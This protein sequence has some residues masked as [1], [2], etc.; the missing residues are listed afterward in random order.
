M[1]DR[2]ITMGLSN[3]ST[4]LYA[5]CS[6]GGLTAY[7]HT[8]YIR[9]RLPITVRVL[10]LADA[11]FSLE[12]DGFGGKPIY[13]PRMQWVY[14]AMNAS[15]SVN[16]ACLKACGSGNGWKCMF[17]ANVAPFIQTP[18]FIL[19]SKYDT[20]QEKVIV[21][22]NC[23]ITKCTGDKRSFWVAYGR[24]MVKRVSALPP[25]HAAFISNCA[26]HCQT[27]TGGHWGKRSVKG[28]TISQA[29]GAWFVNET[30]GDGFGQAA[31]RWVETCDVNTCGTDKC[32]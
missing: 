31:G 14:R 22:V 20:W 19:N 28:M 2:L 16:Q 30:T 4:L 21:G 25:R 11:M 17:G 26:A 24:E 12:H 15:A 3:A 29:V 9:S 23:T 7:L 32:E 1:V 8:D 6:A 18:M 5:G 10:G 27:G 13:Q